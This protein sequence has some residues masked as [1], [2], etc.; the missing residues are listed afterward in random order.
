MDATN[1]EFLAV[2]ARF[3]A[4]R[5]TGHLS[6]RSARAVTWRTWLATVYTVCHRL[7]IVFT[8]GIIHRFCFLRDASV[9]IS[10]HDV[11]RLIEVKCCVISLFQRH[12]LQ[13]V[14]QAGSSVC[15][16]QLADWLVANGVN[17]AN[18]V[19]FRL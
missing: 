18:L 2:D 12:I 10:V 3:A 4:G 8:Q 13:I 11:I 17:V 6:R 7:I 19:C 1:H 16:Q 9:V 15:T 14:Y 5:R